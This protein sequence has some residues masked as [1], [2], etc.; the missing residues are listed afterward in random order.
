M[1]ERISLDNL[2]RWT[3]ETPERI[4]EWRA[5]GLI[6]RG[7]ESFTSED[8][9]LAGLIQLLLRRGISIESIAEAA[10]DLG[11][12]LASYIRLLFPEGVP[13]AYRVEEAAALAGLDPDSV[14]RLLT[15]VWP[16]RS[17]EWVAEDDVTLLQ[18][19]KF[20]LD[21]GFPEPTV[22]DLLRV[23]SDALTRVA[24]AETRLAS[25]FAPSGAW[26][27]QT[28]REAVE[29]YRLSIERLM[30]L[31][32]PVV[33]Y[34]HRKALLQASRLDV[35]R[36]L[37]ERFGL[38]ARPPE[39]GQLEM[40]VAF[41]DLSSFTPM[42]AE[43][44]DQIA[45]DVLTRFSAIVR[46]AAYQH[47]GSVVKQ[48]GDAFMLVFPLAS[49]AASCLLDVDRRASTEPHFP[50]LRG[51]IA[52]GLVL[53]REGDYVGSLV[54]V[55]SRLADTAERH[56]VLVTP[57]VRKEA[58]GLE[59]VEF[60]PAGKR[61]LKGIA[62]ELELFEVRRVDTEPAVRVL[63]PVCGMELGPG[64][65]AVSL[66]LDGV[67]HSFCSE[68]CLRKFVASPERYKS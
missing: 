55:A 18:T 27:G 44:G 25:F 37:A 17:V 40:A 28:D 19:F 41:I 66:S 64:E 42:T 57:E 11:A 4:E 6:S 58:A 14:R 23:Y 8:L 48:I 51:G 39:P 65:V 9:E 63:D 50:A 60:A 3:G 52:F 34:F 49:S 22:I 13:R 45:A 36:S 68:D 30:P 32:A 35:A 43:M 20:V 21:S 29:A 46:E 26:E 59:G 62:D 7:S 10:R 53:Y 16:G 24:E 15:T 47:D 33:D 54:N 61:R 38:S 1:T 56:Q 12:E 31:A 67:A 5:L 2:A